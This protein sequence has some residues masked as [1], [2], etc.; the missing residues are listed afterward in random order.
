MA[1]E[2]CQV[3]KVSAMVKLVA[4][5]GRAEELVSAFD[6]LFTEAEREPGTQFYSLNR[7]GSDPNTFWFYELYADDEALAAHSGSDA[8]KEAMNSFGSLVESTEM[9]FGN[10]V[11]A[12]GITGD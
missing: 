6:P 10:L 3:A 8:M 11:R 5:S 9:I 2:E 12:K 7:S 4:K 1:E